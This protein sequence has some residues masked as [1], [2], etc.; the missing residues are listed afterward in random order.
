MFIRYR[1]LTYDI[2]CMTYDIVPQHENV[3]YTISYVCNY[4]WCRMSAMYDIVCAYR[5]Q[6]RMSYTIS[7][8][9]VW[10]HMLTYDIVCIFYH[11]MLDTISYVFIRYRMSTDRMSYIRHRMSYIRHRMSV[12]KAPSMDFKFSKYPPPKACAYDYRVSYS[13]NLILG[14]VNRAD[15]WET[16]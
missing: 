6:Y 8:F 3:S 4:S 2:V 16:R 5:M 14:R 13:L 9:C 1:M 11:R 10:Y 7:Y 15:M 12:L